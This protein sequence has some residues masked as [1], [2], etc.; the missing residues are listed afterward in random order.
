MGHTLTH[1]PQRMQAGS[2]MLRSSFSQK[3]RTPL[4]PLPTGAAMSCW[5]WPIM[6]P[7]TMILKVLFFT[8][9]QASSRSWMGVP[10]GQ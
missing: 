8:P 3:A 7:P 5:A 10:M 6:G 9:P 4:V 1:L 2:G